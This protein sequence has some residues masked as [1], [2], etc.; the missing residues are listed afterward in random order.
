MAKKTKATKIS[1][2]RALVKKINS[3]LIDASFD[4][5][6]NTAKTGE[7][8]QKLAN[9]LIKKAEP[10]SKKQKAMLVESAE[11]IKTQL[12]SGTERLKDLVGY[13]PKTLEGAKKMIAENPVV[14]KAGEVKGKIEKEI[15]NNKLVVKAE[16][17]TSKLTKKISDTIE[18]VKEKIEEYTEEAMEAAP[19]KK[20]ATKKAAPR[21]SQKKGSDTAKAKKTVAKKTK[22]KKTTEKK[23]EEKKIEVPTSD[24]KDD[25]KLIKGIGPKLEEVLNG[26]GLTAFEQIKKLTIKDMTKLLSDAGV[27]T[28]L[29][30]ISGWKKQAKELL[31]TPAVEA[32]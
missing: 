30:D 13:D 7:K 20:K 27:N 25:L 18:E 32:E 2:A 15:A 17:M 16:K 31:A 5:F 14:E 3:D 28:K 29:Y 23:V 4:A 1:Q 24:K 26:I 21:S 22:A 6:E 12:A 19:A 10:I 9:K 8:W 11:T